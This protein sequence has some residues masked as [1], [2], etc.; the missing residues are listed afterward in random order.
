[1]TKIGMTCIKIGTVLY[2]YGFGMGTKQE[3]DYHEF[4]IAKVGRDYVYDKNDRKVRLVLNKDQYPQ[5]DTL[6]AEDEDPN[7]RYKYFLSSDGSHK[8]LK[9]SKL[10]VALSRNSFS[11]PSDEVILQIATLM[12]LS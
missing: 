7:H 6:I 10:R 4:E 3:G 2:G 9:V 1:M 11:Q 5:F 12:G 8:G